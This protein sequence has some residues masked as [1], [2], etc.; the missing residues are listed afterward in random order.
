MTN[1]PAPDDLPYL[2]KILCPVDFS[3]FSPPVLAYAVAL[4]KLFG[5]EVTVL[6]VFPTGIPPANQVTYPSWLLQVP[7]ARDAI[8][9]ELHALL[10]PFSATGVTLRT[11]VAEGNTA[12]EIV[13]YAGE[14]QMDLIVLGTHGRSGFDRFALGSVAEKI[15]RKAP[16]PVMT[17]PPGM[18]RAVADVSLR[19][20]LW[21]TDFSSCSEEALDFALSL[22]ARTHAGVTALHVVE[23]LDSR[24]ESSAS[25]AVVELHQRQRETEL[26]ALEAVSDARAGAVPMENLVV[27][28][29]P[30]LAIVEAAASRAA[31]LIVMGVRGRGAVDITLFG[32]TTNQVVRRAQCPVVTIRSQQGSAR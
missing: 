18:P 25:G 8:A 15:L 1:A 29:R 7:E 14:G 13:R 24:P 5:G 32:S 23:T 20:I 28:G 4:A 11:Q 21:P 27:L 22:A 19:R 12:A 10:A 9:K 31:D 16:C 3:D 26:R 2:R 6:H 30:Y 17:L